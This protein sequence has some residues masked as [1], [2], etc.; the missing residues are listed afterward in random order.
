MA[1]ITAPLLSIGA[2][3]SIAKTLVA[4]KW[5]GRP[6][7]RQ[8][9]IPANPNS[10]EQ[11][12]TR[13][14]FAF[15]QAVWKLAPTDFTDPWNSAA[16]GQVL[17]GRNLLTSQNVKAMRG[18]SDL[19]NM[20][21]SPGS[22]GGPAPSAVSAVGGGSTGEIDVTITAPSTPPGWTLA[23]F[24]AATINAQDPQSGTEYLI[25]AADNAT[26]PVTIS[27]LTGGADYEVG[28]WLKWTKPDGTTAYGASQTDTATATA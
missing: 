28:G 1:K 21:F 5:K 18:D 23:A 8:H 20:I 10:T 19:T 4:S 13:S 14:L 17:T 22:K 15:L 26:S 16:Q 27:G 2:S 3:G 7:F 24:V 6:Y 11:Q 12:V 9:V 25:T